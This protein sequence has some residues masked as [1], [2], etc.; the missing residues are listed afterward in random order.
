MSKFKYFFILFYILNSN[1]L[2]QNISKKEVD[3]IL[4]NKITLLNK[5]GRYKEAYKL[6]ISAESISHN[7]GY[8][9]GEAWSDWKK[10][11]K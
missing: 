7:I 1:A 6:G 9:K 5:N 8:L 11:S 4:F 3:D 10:R 2:A